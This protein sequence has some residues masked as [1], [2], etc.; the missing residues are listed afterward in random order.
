MRIK[1]QRTAV[2]CINDLKYNTL[3]KFE[4]MIF[5]SVGV[6]GDYFKH[7][8]ASACRIL[9]H[10]FYSENNCP[11]I[12]AHRVNFIKMPRDKTSQLAKIRPIW[13]PC[14]PVSELLPSKK[15]NHFSAVAPPAKKCTTDQ[16]C[17]QGDQI[18]RIFAHWVIV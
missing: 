14:F 2:Q 8:A 13:S 12:W 15:K 18:G 7:H 1:L 10:N 5:C 4:L 3:A 6:D 9:L 17:Q 16:G 11:N